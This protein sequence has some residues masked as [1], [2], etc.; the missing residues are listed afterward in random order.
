MSEFSKIVKGEITITA[1]ELKALGFFLHDTQD[2]VHFR[3][4]GV[5]EKYI[6]IMHKALE[7]KLILREDK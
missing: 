5:K 6:D 2:E 4:V 7:L 3:V 1:G